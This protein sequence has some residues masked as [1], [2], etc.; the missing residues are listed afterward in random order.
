[1]NVS[2]LVTKIN[3]L[4]KVQTDY[5]DEQEYNEEIDT[6]L[7]NCQFIEDGLDVDKRR[8]LSTSTVVYEHNDQYFGLRVI[9]DIYNDMTTYEDCYEPITAF[10]M[11]VYTVN[12]Y[13]VKK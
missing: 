6:F 7:N 11:E 12:S 9:E 8:H 4:E 3:E 2:E 5:Y 10:E 1:M 13:K